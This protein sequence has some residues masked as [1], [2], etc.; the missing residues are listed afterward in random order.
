MVALVPSGH[1]HRCLLDILMATG[2]RISEALGLRWRNVE[3]DTHPLI[4]VAEAHYKG[5]TNDP[6]TPAGWREIPIPPSLAAKLKKRRA[7]SDWHGDDDLVFPTLEGK[8]LDDNYL[9]RKFLGPIAE[10]MGVPWA[11]KFHVLRHTACSIMARQGLRE[12]GGRDSERQR[13]RPPSR[14]RTPCPQSW[15][16]R[17]LSGSVRARPLGHSW[18]Q[19]RGARPR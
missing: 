18:V 12:G 1:R 5:H 11:R 7:E 6:K 9:R 14:C 13:S 3:L 8:P 10:E 19:Q 4:R 15:S 2:M 16:R 17:S